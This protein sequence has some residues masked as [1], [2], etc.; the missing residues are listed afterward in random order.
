[1]SYHKEL[2][3]LIKDCLQPKDIEKKHFWGSV[4]FQCFLIDEMIDKL[5]TRVWKK[6]N[7]KLLK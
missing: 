1:M 6:N 4:S 3:E 7:N 2:L 5:P